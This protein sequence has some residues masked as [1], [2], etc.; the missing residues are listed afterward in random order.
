[1][2]KV[3]NDEWVCP[4]CETVNSGDICVICGAKK[5]LKNKITQPLKLSEDINTNALENIQ[6]N[7]DE[8]AQWGADR[9]KRIVAIIILLIIAISCAVPVYLGYTDQQNYQPVYQY[10]SNELFTSEFPE[11]P[12]GITDVSM[13][14]IACGDYS[15]GYNDNKEIVWWM[16][17]IE[18]T[19]IVK[20][21][22]DI[23]CS[24]TSD[25]SLDETLDYGWKSVL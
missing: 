13:N 12:L 24:W 1:M 7:S 3:N 20:E 4:V 17:D 5:G 11:N 9:W 2:N 16:I 10:D 25:I 18:Y 21:D 8:E 22:L 19:N 23:S 6:K 15:I 14:F